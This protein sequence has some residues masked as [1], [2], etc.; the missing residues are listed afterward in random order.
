MARCKF[1]VNAITEYETCYLYDL[2]EKPST[3]SYLLN[4]ESAGNT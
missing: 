1:R 4:M 3:K 2:V